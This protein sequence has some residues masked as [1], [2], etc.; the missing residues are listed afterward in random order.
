M[1]PQK[2]TNDATQVVGDLLAQEEVF[3]KPATWVQFAAGLDGRANSH[4]QV[5]RS[6]RLDFRD[7]GTLRPA[8]SV[9]QLGATLT[10][11]PLAVDVGKQFIRWGKTDVVTPTDYFAPRD[12]LS[13]VDNDLLAVTGVRASVQWRSESIDAVWVPFFTPSRTPLLNQRWTAVPP[14]TESITV[15]DASGPL[16]VGSQSGVRLGHVSGRYEFSL[17]YFDGFNHLPNISITPDALSTDVEIAKTYP[18]SRSYGFDLA[19]PTRWL[20]LK[21]EAAYSTSTTPETDN[22]VL[23]VVQFERQTGEWM[24]VVGYAG[25]VVTEHRAQFTFAPDRGLTRSI[26][27]R[28]SSRSTPTGVRPS[29]RPSDKTDTAHT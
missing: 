23:Y 2:A 19:V 12:Y 24:F 8:L 6:W 22:Y 5:E 11:G 3:W 1:F 13:V 7:R 29:K 9:R 28:A 27:A 14:G 16:P 20:T 25:E 26:V 18:R 21:A 4:D 17:S 10:H 15:S